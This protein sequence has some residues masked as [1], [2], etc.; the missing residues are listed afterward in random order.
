MKK[1][2]FIL[3]IILILLL[4][5]SI[6]AISTKGLETKKFNDLI[7]NK[8]IEKNKDISIKLEKIRFQLKVSK[9]I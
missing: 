7:S 1:I 4:S 8:I 5:I 2:S 6:I 3:S 9:F